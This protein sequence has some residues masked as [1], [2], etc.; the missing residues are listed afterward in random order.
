MTNLHVEA[1]WDE[2]LSDY[3]NLSDVTD[4]IERQIKN[5]VLGLNG[6]NLDVNVS[7]VGTEVELLPLGTIISGVDCDKP[8]YVK[9]TSGWVGLRPNTWYT[10]EWIG[11]RLRCGAKILYNPGE[12]K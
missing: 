3:E 5:N 12:S 4:S 10:N 11:G 8:F 7:V 9:T 2:S 6:R 1:R